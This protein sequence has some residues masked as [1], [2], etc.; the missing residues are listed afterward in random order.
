GAVRWK[1]HADKPV[2]AGVTPTAG[3][4]T[5]AGDLGGNFLVFDSKSGKLV[6]KAPAGGAMAGGLV[7]YEVA[8]KQYVAYAAGNISRNAFGDLG[9]P[10]V[11]VMT[12]DPGRAATA[13]D[14]TGDHAGDA[15]LGQRLYG[16]VCQSCHGPDG[17][18]LADHRLAGL[19]ARRDLPSTVAYIKNPKA[20]MP[21]MYPELLDDK[22][23]E[24]VANWIYKELR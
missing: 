14:I 7:T 15:G 2:V 13:I 8:G 22:S 23:V 12:L 10:S 20:P 6:H 9:M 16:Q 11:V 4:I 24:A 21:R 3:G 5:F 18:M 19:A 17:N 1:Y